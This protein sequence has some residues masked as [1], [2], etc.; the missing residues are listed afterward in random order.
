MLVERLYEPSSKLSNYKHQHE[1]LG[2]KNIELHNLYRALDY[3]SENHS[4][5]QQLIYNKG[6]NLFNQELDVVFYD[7]TTF[8]FH[9]D[10]D[11]GFRKNGFDKDNKIGKTSIVFGMLIDKDKNPIGYRIYKGGQ[12]EGIMSVMTALSAYQPML[13]NYQSVKY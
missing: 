8:Y 9:S 3:L 7:V 13:S 5:V 4:M 6:R 12:Y 10:K 11:D 2:L 1:Y